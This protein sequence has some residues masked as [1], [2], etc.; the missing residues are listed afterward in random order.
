VLSNLDDKSTRTA[1][2]DANGSFEFLNVKP[3]RYEIAVQAMGFASFKMSSVQLDARQT[4]RVNISLNF[5]TAAQ[6]IE[7]GETAAAIEGIV[8]HTFEGK[9]SFS[10]RTFKEI[11]EL[12]KIYGLRLTR[13]VIC[14][15]SDRSGKSAICSGARGFV[16]RSVL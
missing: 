3:G 4:L 9:T 13:T 10:D 8:L 12:K 1:V 6:T 16:L 5:A 15:G 2:A 7:V 14:Y 11:S